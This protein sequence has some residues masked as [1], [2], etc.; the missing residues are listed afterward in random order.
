[1][2]TVGDAAS[3][4]ARSLAPPLPFRSHTA[5]PRAFSHT[6]HAWSLISS[7][8]CLDF[9]LWRA[10]SFVHVGVWRSC[11]FRTAR[12]SG[13][14]ALWQALWNGPYSVRFQAA[15]RI[16]IDRMASFPLGDHGWTLARLS[17]RRMASN[18]RH[19]PFSLEG[20]HTI[21]RRLHRVTHLG[22]TISKTGAR[23]QLDLT[24]TVT[25]RGSATT[26]F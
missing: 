13:D 7:G 5:I 26:Q 11:S 9:D 17:S 12:H 3:L 19:R 2:L 23:G 24:T 1:M 10:C 25:R 14:A 21:A 8:G 15:A 16:E 22:G 4:L 18:P 20:R 6:V